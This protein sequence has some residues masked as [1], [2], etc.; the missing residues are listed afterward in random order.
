MRILFL[1]CRYVTEASKET[2]GR[3]GKVQDLQDVESQK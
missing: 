1:I 2:A 3:N